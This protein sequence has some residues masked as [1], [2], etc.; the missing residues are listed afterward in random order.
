[1]FPERAYDGRPTDLLLV[2]ARR[3]ATTGTLELASLGPGV[4]LDVRAW[5][6][7]RAEVSAGLAG[8]SL[9][10]K[11]DCAFAGGSAESQL[12]QS[13]DFSS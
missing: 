10:L 11:H 1:M 5:S 4:G 7:G 8:G 13:Q 2:T 6:S 3:A 9:A 12:V